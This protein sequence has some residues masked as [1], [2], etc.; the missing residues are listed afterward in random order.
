MAS[1]IRRK[2]P[3]QAWETEVDTGGGGGGSESPLIVRMA[4]AFDTPDLVTTTEP[5]PI[6]AVD[7]G[8]QTFTVAGDQTAAFAD[9]LNFTVSGSTGN[10][11][12]YNCVTSV[13]GSGV[14]VITTFEAIPDATVDGD[15]IGNV[16]PVG[17]VIYTPTP[18]DVLPLGQSFVV[19]PTAFDGNNPTVRF[20]VASDRVIFDNSIGEPPLTDEDNVDS[21]YASVIQGVGFPTSSVVFTTAEPIVVF[22]DDG[23]GGAP[24]STEGEGEMI[25]YIVKASA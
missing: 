1:L 19:L 6:T 11:G 24:G 10:D 15:A 12:T 8:D 22:V 21:A 5:F 2:D 20:G 13:F 7:Q 4:I 25:L 23:N 3:G 16:R 14:T 9:G 18:G 17:I